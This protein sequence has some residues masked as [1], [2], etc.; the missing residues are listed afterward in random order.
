[1]LQLAMSMNAPRTSGH[2]LLAAAAQLTDEGLVRRLLEIAGES[3]NVTVEL[4][5]H[6]GELDE[7]RLHRGQGCGRLFAYCTEIL[8]LSEGAACNRIRSARAARRFPVI[9]DLLAEGRVNLTTV[10]LLA[11]HLT[12]ENHSALLAETSGM[13]RRGVDKVVARLAPKPD[14][15]AS[16]RKLPTR[17]AASSDAGGMNPP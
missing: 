1:M 10:R 8:K 6:L 9:L 15:P 3:R 4:L 13:K 17:K 7:R 5:A 14:V 2:T 16:L 11:P 12:P